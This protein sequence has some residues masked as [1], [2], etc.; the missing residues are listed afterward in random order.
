MLKTIAKRLSRGKIIKR[1]LPEEFGKSPLYVSPDARLQHLR[2]GGKGFDQELLRIVAKE[3][4]TDSIVWDIGANVGAFAFAAA[5]IAKQGS[6]LAVEAD[7]WLVQLLRKSANLKANQYLNLE[8]LP[9]AI[10]QQ[11]GIAKFLISKNGRAGN[12]LESA[13]GYTNVTGGTREV[14][15]VPTLTLDTLLDFYPYPTFVKIDVEGAE[16]EVLKGGSQILNEIRPSFYI[17]VGNECRKNVTQLFQQS[18]YQL[19]DGYRKVISSCIANTIAI[20]IEKLENKYST[21]GIELDLDKC[22]EKLNKIRS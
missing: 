2:I 7:I 14:I 13:G 22:T 20:P 11:N 21:L 18:N 3:I 4:H 5:S 12:S 19:F 10:S 6:V 1:R 17:E 15:T 9:V 8:I 16:L